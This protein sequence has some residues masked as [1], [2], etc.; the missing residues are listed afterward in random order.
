V[1]VVIRVENRA[2]SGSVDVHPGVFFLRDESGKVHG[3]VAAG[4]ALPN[5][6]VFTR[7]GPG[8][9]ITGTVTFE[10]P[11]AQTQFQVSGLGATLELY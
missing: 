8:M 10:V 6:F 2:A 5:A 3:S 7:L 9:T 11:V 4:S 1:T